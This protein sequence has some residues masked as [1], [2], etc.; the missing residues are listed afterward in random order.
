MEQDLKLQLARELRAIM[1]GW[2]QVGAAGM[3]RMRQQ[4]VSRIWR[5]D[6]AGFSATRLLR[7]IT[8]RGYHTEVHFKEIAR[9]FSRPGRPAEVPTV[10]VVRYDRYGRV[11]TAGK[12]R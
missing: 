8:G 9:R 10:R 12:W 7:L 5:G 3:L 1:N 4:D 11:V 2:S 6:L